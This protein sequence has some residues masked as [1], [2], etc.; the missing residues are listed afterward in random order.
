KTVH[1]EYMDQSETLCPGSPNA[2]SG[3]GKLTLRK[4]WFS[5]GDSRLGVTTPYE[6]TY[7]GPNPDYDM[8]GNDRWGNYQP[9]TGIGNDIF[10]YTDQGAASDIHSRAWNLTSVRTPSG[11]YI[12]VEYE[13]DD[14][15]YVQ[16]KP[17]MRMLRLKNMTGGGHLRDQNILHFDVPDEVQS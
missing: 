10:P 14:Y 17:A 4:V 3:W 15:A 1:F 12:S 5:Y 6:F 9:N 8:N 11:A 7:E 2:A 13:A 16:D